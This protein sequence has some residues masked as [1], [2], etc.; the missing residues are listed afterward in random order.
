MT[1]RIL[2]LVLVAALSACAPGAGTERLSAGSTVDIA[3]AATQ[4]SV[5]RAGGGIIRPLVHSPALQ[6]AAQAQADDLRDADRLGHL[7]AGGSTLADRLQR[8]GYTACAAVENVASDTPDIRTTIARWMA[9]PEHRANILNPQVTQFGFASSGQT[10]VLVL[11][12][13]C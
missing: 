3:S 13:P 11:A 2:A 10:W 9:S 5:Q 12:R 1:P 7:G 4:L 6:G 8:A